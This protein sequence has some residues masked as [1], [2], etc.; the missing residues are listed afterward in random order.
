MTT[1]VR[2]NTPS[3]FDRMVAR[4]MNR[5]FN[6]PATPARYRG[7][8]TPAVTV[9]EDETAYHLAVAMPGVKKEDFTLN[10]HENTLTLAYKPADEAARHPFRYD[11]F[12]RT[13][14]L[15]KNVSAD[16]I[17]AAYTDGILT[18]D[19]PKMELKKAEP[20]AIAIA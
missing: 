6:R 12:E 11:A 5:F 2:Y 7:Q 14:R 20:K 9:S 18:V 1:L 3:L 13:F 4:E 15:P 8:A 16:D 19:L 10:V 17:K